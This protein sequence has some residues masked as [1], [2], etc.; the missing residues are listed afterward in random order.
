[1]SSV[2]V[3]RKRLPSE[4]SRPMMMPVRGDRRDFRREA[5]HRDAGIA[6]NEIN[7]MVVETELLRPWR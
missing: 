6:I 2:V 7:T 4:S 1:A 3:A 5:E